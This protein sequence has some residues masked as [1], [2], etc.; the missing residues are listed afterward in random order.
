MWTAAHP[1]GRPAG[2]DGQGPAT[3]GLQSGAG[4]PRNVA[5]VCVCFAS[6]P[7]CRCPPLVA[8]VTVTPAP[9]IVL[10][11]YRCHLLVLESR[12][13]HH[14]CLCVSLPGG[15]VSSPR[16]VAPFSPELPPPLCLCFGPRSVR[17]S[18]RLGC[19][20]WPGPG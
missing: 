4:G 14:L 20:L 19:P 2:Q 15:T 7:R 6:H 16:L 10:L 13:L 1:G 8:V 9:P 17:A 18:G 3:V 11:T 5:H 12:S